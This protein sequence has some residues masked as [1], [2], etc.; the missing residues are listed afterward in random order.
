M[1]LFIILASLLSSCAIPQPTA[2]IKAVAAAPTY[3]VYLAWDAN[4][5]NTTG[6]KLYRGTKS[7][8]YTVTQDAGNNT[9]VLSEGLELDQKYYFAVTAYNQTGESKPSTE[10]SVGP[11]TIVN[12]AFDEMYVIL[13]YERSIPQT[14]V[15][16]QVQSTQDFVSWRDHEVI[17]LSRDVHPDGSMTVRVGVNKSEL[18]SDHAFFRIVVRVKA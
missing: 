4:T 8:E 13:T 16:Y 10:V 9:K 5:D 14:R 12:I 2:R 6:Y 18:P 15:D 11:P 1:K 3:A 17:E 7:R